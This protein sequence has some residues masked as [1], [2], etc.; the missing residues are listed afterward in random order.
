MAYANPP[1]Q[2]AETNFLFP[3]VSQEWLRAVQI[4][5]PEAILHFLNDQRY[6]GPSAMPP[7]ALISARL[8]GRPAA[9]ACQGRPQSCSAEV[10][11]PVRKRSAVGSQREKLV[12]T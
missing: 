1:P 2:S 6:F 3:T 8:R 5:T 7:R 12:N 9:A 4:K 10:E 11:V